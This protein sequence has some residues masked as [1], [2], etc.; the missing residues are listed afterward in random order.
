MGTQAEYL[1]ALTTLSSDPSGPHTIALTADIDLDVVISPTYSGTPALKID[2]QGHTI[3][4]GGTGRI[5]HVSSAAALTITDV[6]LQKGAFHVGAAITSGAGA[7]MVIDSTLTGNTATSTAGLTAAQGGAIYSG[8][9]PVEILRS[10][11]HGNSA[12]GAAA[13]DDAHGGAIYLLSGAV[14]ITDSTL[15]QNRANGPNITSGG[16]VYTAANSG[17]PSPG[18]VTVTNSILAQNRSEKTA[19]TGGSAAGGAIY[20]SATS[21]I[22]D[23]LLNQN[24]ALSAG[25]TAN[26]GGLRADAVSI[27]DSAFMSNAASATLSGRGGAVWVFDQSANVFSSTFVDN[28]GTKD[29]AA[30]G[31]NAATTNIDLHHVTISGNESPTSQ[32]GVGGTLTTFATTISDPLGGGGNCGA[33]GATS[34]QYSYDTD[35]TCGFGGGAGDVS[36]G[37]DPLLGTPR[38][39][40]DLPAAAEAGGNGTV[41]P[42]MYPLNGSPLTDA[43]PVGSC[44]A[45][46]ALDLDQR[47]VDRPFGTGCDI[48]AIESVFPAHSMSDV[49]P[50]YEPTVRWVTSVVN[51]PQILSGFANGTFGQTLPINRGQTARL[52]YRAAG[53]PDVTG[54]PAHGFSD[55]SPFFNDAVTWAKAEGLFDGFPNGTFRETNPINRGNY[56]RSLYNFVGAPDVSGLPGH[57]FSDVTLFYEDAVKWAKGNGLADGFPGGLYKQ[58]DNIN[59]GNA[60]RIFY[61]TAQSPTAWDGPGTAPRNMLFRPN[62]P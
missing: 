3:D 8:G 15:T 58:G 21:T 61:N 59:R 50:F 11:V 37:A 12:I 20:S 57:G 6:T 33:L 53:A 41:R 49:T 27:Y 16:A 42:T 51:T 38:N 13:G 7:V 55:V 4:R 60:S 5:L 26:G 46:P 52:Y 22:H 40:G 1:D 23:S 18:N 28:V 39:N 45:L 29:A 14:T 25:S 47:G 56:T 36:N 30:I 9:G 34:S 31:G 54:L 24:V 62:L 10:T 35:G 2:G 48:G 32:V 43:V 19:A 44:S 17:A